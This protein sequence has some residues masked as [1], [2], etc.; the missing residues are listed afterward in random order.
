MG[1]V[2]NPTPRPLYLQESPGTRCRGDCVRGSPG[3]VWSG[4]EKKKNLWRTTEFEPQTVKPVVN[5]YAH[6]LR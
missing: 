3:A 4:M 6:Y 5:R 2:A 1:W